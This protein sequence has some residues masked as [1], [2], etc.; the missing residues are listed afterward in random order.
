MG[1]RDYIIR[2]L[3]LMIPIVLGVVVLIFAIIQF[4]PVNSRVVVYMS[5]SVRELNPAVIQ[6]YI[7]MYGLDQ[8]IWV[9]FANWLDQVIHG[10]FGYSET[11]Q[12]LVLQGLLIRIP[13]TFEIVLF[14]APLIIFV[15][16]W[17][18]VKS[19][20]QKDKPF[21]QGT[22]IFA[23]L[24]TSLPSF[25]FGIILTA[26]FIGQLRWVTAGRLS[27]GLSTDLLQLVGKGGW[28]QYTSLLTIDSL[29]NLRPNYFVDALEHL[30]LPVTV[31][32][33]IQTA[34]LVRVTR[35]SM[36]EALS[37]TYVTAARAKGL[38]RN[39]VIY[40][41]ARRNALI[42]VVTIS[43]LLVGG[44]MTGLIITE[45]I[46]LFPGIGSWAALAAQ[47]FDVPVVAA[48][49]MFSAVIFVLANLIVDVLYA[50]IDPRI[51]LG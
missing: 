38:T 42:P 34:V 50:Y 28:H 27:P 6:Q 46:F 4:V 31:L 36:L 11:S 8:P 22:R 39:E 9:Q 14:A 33:F 48:Y 30:V 2:R 1:L 37:K 3:L 25:F 51:R 43:G 13:A 24:G 35:S 7:H 21:D 12:E 49:A 26:I 15:G 10:N 40:K 16:I 19:A 29:L 32:V 20:V 17:L 41:H 45:T 44:M 5:G 18:G 23:I 47:R